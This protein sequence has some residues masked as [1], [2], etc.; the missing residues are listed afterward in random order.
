[1]NNKNNIRINFS[2]PLNPEDSEFQTYG[3]R[4]TNPDNCLN[5]DIKGVCAFACEDCIC[6]KPS[7]AWKR[8][9]HKLKEQSNG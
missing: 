6:R 1:M 7:R 5:V 3:C 9:F 2:A 4:A 8:Q